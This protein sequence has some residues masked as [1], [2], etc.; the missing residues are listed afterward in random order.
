MKNIIIDTDISNNIDD[1]FAL[2]YALLSTELN[3]EAITIAP[4]N[5]SLERKSLYDGVLDSYFEAK[6]ICR[7]ARVNSKIVYKGATDYVSNGFN[8][9]TKAV[10]KIL[11]IAKKN[12]KTYILCLGPLTN[13]ALALKKNEQIKDKIEVIWLGLD[14]L[15]CDKFLDKNYL[16]DIDAFNYV[17]CSGLKL[18]IIPQFVGKFN[19]TSVYELKEHVAINPLGKYLLKILENS[20][21]N[22]ENRGLKYIFSISGIA[23]LKND[24]FYQVKDLDKQIINKNGLNNCY[25]TFNYVYDGSKENSVWK[26]FILTIK[27]APTDIFSPKTFFISDTHF[28][29]V[30]KGRTKENKIGDYK[31]TDHEY[32]KKWNSVVGK[33]D[34]VYHLGDFGKYEII[35]K[36]NGQVILICGNY[37]MLD[38]KDDFESFRDRLIKM[39]FKDVVLEG[40]VL[41]KNVLGREVYLTHKPESCKKDM[42]NLFGHVHSLKPIMKNGFN[43]CTEYHN[44]TPLSSYYIK[45]YI[46]FILSAQNDTNCFV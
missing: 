39:G 10:E 18:T 2:G 1:Q 19:S 13:I 32:I 26:D 40:L 21:E 3:V 42:F 45:N 9:Q 31:K 4:Y 14:N 12:Q 25:G 17:L 46:D 29:Q 28:S 36:L 43:V 35:K 33:K 16:N 41:D 23:Y 6:R 34:I 30:N 15:Y 38:I 11:E 37:E 44:F 7:L 27:K 5:S 24:L 20:Y 8:Q 22:I